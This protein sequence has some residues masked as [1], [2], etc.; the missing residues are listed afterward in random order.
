MWT[1][2]SGAGMDCPDLQAL[3]RMTP[4]QVSIAPDILQAHLQIELIRWTSLQRTAFVGGCIASAIARRR[5]S[6]CY[7]L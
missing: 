2:A 5:A 7:A 1:I 4:A 3:H 6:R